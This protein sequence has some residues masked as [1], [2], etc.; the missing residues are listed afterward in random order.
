MEA[1]LKVVIQMKGD[2]ALVGVQGTNTDP[3]VEA[4]PATS[5]NDVLAAVPGI[6]VRARERWTTSPKNPAYQRPP[7]PPPQAPRGSQEF[8]PGEA[9]GGAADS[10]LRPAHENGQKHGQ[11]RPLQPSG[12]PFN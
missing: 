4:L 2:R 1:E 8:R 6:L 7:E 12:S 9:R 10:S 3:V 11:T 5:L